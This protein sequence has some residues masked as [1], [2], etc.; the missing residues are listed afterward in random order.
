M[1]DEPTGSLDYATGGTIMALMLALNQEQGTTLVLVTHDLG[2]VAGVADRVLVMYGGR[3]V[4]SGAVGEMLVSPR[5]PYTRALLRSMPRIDDD[6]TAPLT[7]IPG[8][9]PSPAKLPS[10]CAFHPRCAGADAACRDQL[11]AMLEGRTR[12]ACHHPEGAS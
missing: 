6:R 12:A 5:H 8:Q 7:A 4:E 10:G 2:V 11:P 9:P 1:A 3:V